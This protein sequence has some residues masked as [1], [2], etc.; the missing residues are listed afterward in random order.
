MPIVNPLPNNRVPYHSFQRNTPIEPEHANANNKELADK[1]T[2]LINSNND[3]DPRIE[4]I[5]KDIED[6]G[7]ISMG[8][9]IDGSLVLEKFKPEE[10]EL[11]AKQ[12]ELDA[13]SKHA[14]DARYDLLLNSIQIYRSGVLTSRRVSK[15]KGLFYD[16]FLTDEFIDA[17]NSDVYFRSD[18]KLVESGSSSILR[19]KPYLEIYNNGVG[20][21]TITGDSLLSTDL[22]DDTYINVTRSSSSEDHFGLI[23]DLGEEINIKKYRVVLSGNHSY[24]TL[25]AYPLQGSNDKT[26]WTDIEPSSIIASNYSKEV[27]EDTCDV[28]Y[29]YVRV[30]LCLNSASVSNST[31]LRIYS[32]EL[33][34]DENDGRYKLLST[35]E[36]T[37]KQISN[38]FTRAMLYVSA[39]QTGNTVTYTPWVSSD[40]GSTWEEAV[41]QSIRECPFDE[42]YNEYEYSVEVPAGQ[43]IRLKIEIKT[44]DADVKGEITNYGMYFLT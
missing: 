7:E 6:I 36:T 34:T 21:I 44:S 8:Q 15:S 29:R 25:R 39:K 19:G 43:N 37:T 23:Y 9:I 35:L 22:D 26:N 20:S 1:I 30:G 33:Y 17:Q 14:F 16:A 12:E 5:E 13:L 2:E 41:E 3:F 40:G 28:T 18:I 38:E 11:L 4:Q 42:S 10:L 27:F 24:H 31:Y 32:L